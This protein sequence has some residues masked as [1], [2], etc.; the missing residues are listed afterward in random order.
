MF[1]GLL[2]ILAPLI[3]TLVTFVLPKWL[4]F[5]KFKH[6]T[7]DCLQYEIDKRVKHVNIE[8]C[9]TFSFKQI[10][11]F[12]YLNPD[13]WKL[14]TVD[15][16]PVPAKKVELE[17][18]KERYV[19]VVETGK[20]KTEK[21]KDYTY[22]PVFFKTFIDQTKYINWVNKKLAK[23]QTDAIISERNKNTKAVIELVQ[24]D[25]DIIQEQAMKD[26]HEQ[27]ELLTE[28]LAELKNQSVQ[29]MPK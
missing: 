21:E 5:K 14:I 1:W 3:L 8:T 16:Y 17:T 25:I 19:Y 23:E 10:K 11:Q 13:S 26:L 20:Y 24:K 2:I 18:G 22:I 4:R 28:K 12:Y 6:D 27:T 9:P 7:V 29:I 15:N